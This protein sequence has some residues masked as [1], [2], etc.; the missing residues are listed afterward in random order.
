VPKVLVDSILILI[1][2]L[3]YRTHHEFIIE[4]IRRHLETVIDVISSLDEM[5]T[6][7]IIKKKIALNSNLSKK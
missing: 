3:G 1:P 7:K 6:S 5:K 2:E 4:A